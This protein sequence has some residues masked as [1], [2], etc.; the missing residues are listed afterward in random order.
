M[1]NMA[2]ENSIEDG[3][4]TEKPFDA[5]ISGRLLSTIC[6][7]LIYFP[8]VSTCFVIIELVLPFYF[9]KSDFYYPINVTINFYMCRHRSCIFG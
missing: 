8:I 5:L 3:Y 2:F 7:F 6:S 1:F 9:S 4:V